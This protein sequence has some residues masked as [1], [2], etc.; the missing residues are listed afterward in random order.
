MPTSNRCAQVV[1]P[2]RDS[3]RQIRR[4]SVRTR[5]ANVASDVISRPWPGTSLLRDGPAGPYVRGMPGAGREGS[6]LRIVARDGVGVVDRAPDCDPGG[7]FICIR[8]SACLDQ[9]VR[10][11][12]LGRAL[13][14]EIDGPRT[15]EAIRIH[16]VRSLRRTR[17]ARHRVLALHPN[18]GG[19]T[20]QKVGSRS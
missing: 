1:A 16:S 12:S 18:G 7:G 17:A 6:L 19:C 4:D 15:A 14:A 13:R 3:T 11:R 9:A 2:S 5:S 8:G 20:N 10:R